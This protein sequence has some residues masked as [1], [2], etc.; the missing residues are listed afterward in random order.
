MCEHA[1]R[2]KSWNGQSPVRALPGKGLVLMVGVVVTSHAAKHSHV[3][4]RE[5][6]RKVKV[7]PTCISSNASCSRC[8]NS[9]VASDIESYLFARPK[10]PMLSETFPSLAS[11]MFWVPHQGV[12][13]AVIAPEEL[14]FDHEAR[15]A[16]D[17][18]LYSS[19]RMLA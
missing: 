18:E 4:V 6:R 14:A 5:V 10:S 7:C 2:E 11:G 17:A 9:G 12:L 15:G 8:L 13:Q 16:E 3:S 19:L 1:P